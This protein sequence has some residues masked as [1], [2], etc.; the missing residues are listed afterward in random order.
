MV[1]I[2]ETGVD[3]RNPFLGFSSVAPQMRHVD[4][5]RLVVPSRIP[6][7]HLFPLG[8]DISDHFGYEIRIGELHLVC[9][10]MQVRDIERFANLVDQEFQY[11]PPFRALHVMAESTDESG[12]VSRH[13]DLRDQ[14]DMM[15][16]AESG[17]FPCLFQRVVFPRLAGRVDAVVQHWEHLALQAPCLIFRQVPVKDVY[18]VTCQDRY[19]P[20][21][22]VRRDIGASYI[23]HEA[24]DAKGGP[25]GDLASGDCNAVAFLFRQLA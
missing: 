8:A 5:S 13:V 11:L 16:L 20:F 4:L 3:R 7:D 22:F 19:F 14:Q 21:Q 12:T 6:G 24:A 1:Q 25:V 2:V 10:D 18:L 9:P 17:Q 15:L 23:L